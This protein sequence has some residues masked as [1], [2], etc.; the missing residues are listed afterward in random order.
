VVKT[1]E[2]LA[3]VRSLTPAD[4]AQATSDNFFRLFAKVPRPERY[5]SAA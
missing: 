5:R 4:M 3:A 1:L 2:T